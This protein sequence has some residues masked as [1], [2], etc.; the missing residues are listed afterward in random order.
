MIRGASKRSSR[1]LSFQSLTSGRQT[2][3]VMQQ[4][5][6]NLKN[7]Q[8]YHV[9]FSCDDN[10]LAFQY[11]LPA[12]ILGWTIFGTKLTSLTLDVPL[13]GL[14]DFIHPCLRFRQLTALTIRLSKSNPDSDCT[15]IIKEVLKPF[16]NN[17]HASLAA[18]VLTS[19]NNFDFSALLLGLHHFPYLSKLTISHPFVSLQE[20]ATSGLRHILALHSGGLR[21]LGLRFHTP[22]NTYAQLPSSPS[23]FGLPFFQIT[24]SGLEVLDLTLR[25]QQDDVPWAI[26]YLRNFRQTLRSLTLRNYTFRSQEVESLVV[27]FEEGYLEMLDITIDVLYPRLMDRLAETL[28]GL[29]DLRLQFGGFDLDKPTKNQGQQGHNATTN[30]KTV[31]FRHLPCVRP[32]LHSGGWGGGI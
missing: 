28:V 19:I 31:R 18:L 24:L 25:D 9:E 6:G 7:V 16:I 4:I 22:P 21:E 2:L 20:T 8:D 10:L 15:T 30:S 32:P 5:M 13:E 14:R 12:L 29:E 11:A 26:S 17:H 1:R 27:E 23:W 3:E